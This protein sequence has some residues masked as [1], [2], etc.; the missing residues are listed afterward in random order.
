MVFHAVFALWGAS[1]P[2]AGVNLSAGLCCRDGESTTGIGVEKR[3]G[4]FE[5]P[6]DPAVDDE[7]VVVTFA[8]VKRLEVG[9]DIFADSLGL[10]EVHRRSGNGFYITEG[11]FRGVGREV[12]G[13]VELQHLVEDVAFVVA[14]QVEV[15]VVSKVDISSGV[16]SCFVVDGETAIVVP[17]V[18]DFGIKV[19]RVAHF[20]VGAY[21][22]ENDAVSNDLRVPNM[23]LEAIGAS[24]EVV[25][26]IVD[27]EVVFDTVDYD[28]SVLDAV[29]IATGS[30][31]GARTV[32]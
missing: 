7:A 10:G 15:G 31:A 6:F 2:V 28:V 8:D 25:G 22:G 14:F 24:M 3:A 20:A 30:F 19:A 9:V 32:V 18:G 29:G 13:A 26:P 23:V 21:A 1:E 27:G 17:G 12:V 5:L 16:G 11:G 4:H